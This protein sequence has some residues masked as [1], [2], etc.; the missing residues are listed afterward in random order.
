MLGNLKKNIYIYTKKNIYIYK[1]KYIYIYKK[2]NIY[3]MSHKSGATKVEEKIQFPRNITVQYTLT[4]FG[5]GGLPER[6]P[7]STRH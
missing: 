7:A 6:I 2:K 4:F 5:P 1:K 3:S